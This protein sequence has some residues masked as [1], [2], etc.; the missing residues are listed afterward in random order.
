MP[1][2]ALPFVRRRGVVLYEDA[3][4]SSSSIP[5][6]S[7]LVLPESDDDAPTATTARRNLASSTSSP[8]CFLSFNIP[9]LTFLQD[10]WRLPTRWEQADA[11]R[12]V[13][14]QGGRVA[15]TYTFSI[16]DPA[17]HQDG[18]RCHV[19][20]DPATQQP[21]L[22]E[23]Y[24]VAM[25]QALDVA[26][27]LGIRLILP[28]VDQ[29]TWVGG[30]ESLARM[31]GFDGED[32]AA[33]FWAEEVC[34]QDFERI[35]RGVV[36]RTNTLNGVAYRDDPTILA[37]ETGNELEA[38]SAWTRRMAR[39]IRQVDAGEGKGGGL[40]GGGGGGG[41]GKHLIIDGHHGVDPAMLDEES[42]DI[43]SRHYYPMGAPGPGSSALSFSDSLLQDLR[44]CQG[45]KPFYVGEFGFASIPATQAFFDT[46]LL[47][48]QAG[49]GVVGASLWS[50][51]F[52]AA[53]GGF[54]FHE[55]PW[56]FNT[57]WA[58]HW[59]GFPSGDRYDE[60]Q[61]ME[62]MH[63]YGHRLAH[64]NQGDKTK[65]KPTLP[66]PRPAAP[67]LLSV[68]PQG[69][70]T[71]RGATSARAYELQ[72]TQDL[73][74]G[75][76]GWHVVRRGFHDASVP[77]QG[78]V[79]DDFLMRL[80]PGDVFYRLVASNEGG[81]SPPSGVFPLRLPRVGNAPP[82]PTSYYFA[83]AESQH[84]Q[85]LG[86]NKD[87]PRLQGRLD[88]VED[89][90]EDDE[91]WV[92]ADLTVGLGLPRAASSGRP[93]KIRSLG[94]G[95]LLYKGVDGRLYHANT[96]D[97]SVSVCPLPIVGPPAVWVGKGAVQAW[98]RHAK[99]D[100]LW[101][102]SLDPLK[103]EVDCTQAYNLPVVGSGTPVAVSETEV[104]WV[105]KDQHLYRAIYDSS[106]DSSKLK[107]LVDHTLLSKHRVR[108]GE[109]LRVLDRQ[110]VV[111]V[112]AAPGAHLMEESRAGGASDEAWLVT[113][114]T[115]T[116]G[117]PSPALGSVETIR[118]GVAKVLFKGAA[119]L[120]LYALWWGG[121]G[122]R[123]SREETN[124]GGDA[125]EMS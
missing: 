12:S 19:E 106:S 7:S 78:Q 89:E 13:L 4:P 35:I 119:D 72:R 88:E 111:Y 30:I 116:H 38:P 124:G 32:A 93:G 49:Q 58:Y 108:S 29:W 16:Q 117:A 94:G 91:R 55:E 56:G 20:W 75:K 14:H 3:L 2:P 76:A 40:R 54:Y 28:L 51:R 59:P 83:D 1:A 64:G 82:A 36:G 113:D 85:W 104:L 120:E 53:K 99:D 125:M 62:L 87:V 112:S 107:A 80:P 68:T 95:L 23:E 31:R 57:Y 69:L 44:A 39:V 96:V 11:L 33:R 98:V 84:V 74:L 47:Y 34:Q 67:R 17:V 66:L 102:L 63:A 9:E 41:T 26:R 60:R 61:M 101:R 81:R 70:V 86:R 123:V 122:W 97:G 118:Q 79:L 25:D 105:G 27:E 92:T 10:P 71:F 24:M 100:H 5:S 8:Y 22:N 48:G 103:S 115:A 109:E 73:G 43:V 121:D 18:R 65:I 90:E 15:R 42:I 110:K 21:V 77:E 52:R 37:W 46:L 45:K 114:H 6:P 50:L